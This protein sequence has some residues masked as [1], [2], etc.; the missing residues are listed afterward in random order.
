MHLV[1]PRG[2][3]RVLHS[4]VELS[5]VRIDHTIDQYPLKYNEKYVYHL[6]LF[7]T[8]DHLEFYSNYPV[9]SIAF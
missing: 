7:T 2:E 6:S 5:V 9:N 8:F 3:G 1:P 4:E